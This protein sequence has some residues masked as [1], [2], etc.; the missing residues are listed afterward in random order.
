[1]NKK[2]I[3]FSP[4]E[5][6][7]NLFKKLKRIKKWTVIWTRRWGIQSGTWSG[8]S[9]SVSLPIQFYRANLGV[10]NKWGSI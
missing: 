1:M 10:G 5:P 3:L 2:W 6:K 9:S 4:L 8:L 7:V